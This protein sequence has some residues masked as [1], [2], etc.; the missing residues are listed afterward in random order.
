MGVHEKVL[1]VIAKIAD[2]E[3]GEV[4]P[5]MDLV[6]ALGIDSPRALQLLVALEEAFD[7]EIED[8]DAAKMDTVQ[9]I[10]DYFDARGL[11]AA[12]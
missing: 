9:D 6:G 8:E 3:A 4:R 5:E 11:E 12:G 1:Q 7:I 10:L 2:K